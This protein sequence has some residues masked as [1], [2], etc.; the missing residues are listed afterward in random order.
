MGA[1]TGVTREASLALA[2]VLAAA[3][4]ALMAPAFA[5]WGNAGTVI[6]N[7]Y[8]LALVALGMTLLLAMGA[9]DVSVGAVLGVTAILVGQALVAGM[10]LAVAVIVGPLAGAA[11]GLAAGSV[12]VFGRIPA[13][14]ATLGLFGVFRTVIFV[15]LGG[16]W[17]SGLPEGVTDLLAWRG[18]G[19]PLGVLVIALAYGLAWAALRRTPY[20][21]HLLA[22]GQ[23][24]ERARLLGLAVTRVRLL[25]FVASGALCGLAG[26]FYVGIY[27]NVSMT[28][29]ANVALEA[30]A[31]VILGGTAIF[32]GRASLLGTLLGVLL[33]RILQNGLLLVGVPSL[34]QTVV[35]G[36][37]ILVVLVAEGLGGRLRLR[38]VEK[39][40]AP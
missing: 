6:R 20:G 13:I 25:T 15:L 23:S 5:T 31:A 2:C 36:A 29:G 22:I 35:T 16:Q 21:P 9:I 1:G 19:V 39:R 18:L 40:A 38:A 34:W 14:V 24:E 12:V 10:P 8:E 27:R 28:V 7:S 17:L 37:L 32:G 11:M 4:F 33:L 3:V 30:V 26:V